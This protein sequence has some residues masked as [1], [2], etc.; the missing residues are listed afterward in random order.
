[1]KS[2]FAA[3]LKKDG[4]MVQSQFA[5][6]FKK[7][8]VEYKGGKQ[9]KWFEIRLS[10]KTGEITAKYWGRDTTK[11]DELYKS[12][13]SGDV[14]F[15]SGEVSE[16]PKGSSIF[17]ISIDA[18]KGA[19]RKCSASEYDHSDFLAQ[20][21]KNI[22]GMLEELKDL[23]SSIK[24]KHLAEL[25]NSFTSDEK[26]MASFAKSPAAMEYHQN[27]L[28][29]LLE[30]TLNVMR[31]GDT[32]CKIHTELDRDLVIAGAFLH[33][34]GKTV[35]LSTTG[36]TIDISEEGMLIGHTTIGYNMV[37]KQ[38]DR[39][40]EFPENLRLKILHMVLSHNG[41]AEYGS[42]KEPQL[43]EAIAV[44]YSDECDAK[45][46][47]FLRLKREAKTEDPWIWDKKI[48]GHVYLK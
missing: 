7:P 33:D 5:V 24:D 16:Y 25:V 37:S 1:M 4:E 44:Y 40:P 28:G 8:P 18:E 9:G 38:L 22:E 14:V 12:F 35:E 3:D 2:K 30:H 36:T 43:P 13:S 23:L 29:G 39:M 10:D 15:L 32:L 17:S 21:S 20:T 42:P 11:T 47:L 6:K 34:I 27:Y 48:R 31:I 26:F 46:D 45:I 19:L 41:K